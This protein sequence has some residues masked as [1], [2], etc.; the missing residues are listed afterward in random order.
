MLLCLPLKIIFLKGTNCNLYVGEDFYSHSSKFVMM[1]KIVL[2]CLMAAL[3]IVAASSF[4]EKENTDIKTK[5]ALGKKLF[6]EKILSKDSSVS[7]A[8]CHKPQFAFADTF[9]FSVGIAGK[10]TDESLESIF[11]E[12]SFLPREALVLMSVFSSS[13]KELAATISRA[14][15]KQE[16]TNFFIITNLPLWL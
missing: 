13:K 2:S 1:K 16:S 7:C 15:I 6:S 12:K 10:L 11:S 5:A 4:F 9:A 8:S 3:L 14:A